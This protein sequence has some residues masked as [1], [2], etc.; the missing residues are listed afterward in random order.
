[1][2]EPTEEQQKEIQQKYVDYQVLEQQIQQLQKQM[3]KL[4]VQSAEVSAVKESIHEMS[5]AKDSQEILVPV[6]GGIFFKAKVQDSSK[7]LVNVGANVVVE[8]DFEGTKKLIENQ[9]SELEKFKV[10]VNNQLA[11]ETIKHQLLAEELNKLM[12]N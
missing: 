8:K 12:V 4:D 3:E 11:E 1:M 9:M 6:S 7:F 2:A 10:H 5:D